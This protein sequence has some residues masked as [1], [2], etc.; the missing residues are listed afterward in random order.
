[1]RSSLPP[2]LRY[3]NTLLPPGWLSSPSW[4]A[5]LLLWDLTRSESRWFCCRQNNSS[6]YGNSS[7]S[8]PTTAFRSR[9]SNRGGFSP[10]LVPS[11]QQFHPRRN[12]LSLYKEPSL[13]GVS[14]QGGSSCWRGGKERDILPVSFTLASASLVKDRAENLGS[15]EWD[16]EKI[17]QTCRSP[18]YSILLLLID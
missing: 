5:L 2:C 10:S 7:A 4:P 15:D 14:L 1:M 13:P 16:K 17:F 9:L 3:C 12:H 8:P 18:G 6:F 11:Q